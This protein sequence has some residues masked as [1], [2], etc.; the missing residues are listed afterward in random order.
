MVKVK[1]QEETSPFSLLHEF[2]RGPEGNGPL[3]DV[4]ALDRAELA[5]PEH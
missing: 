4:P 5:L 1:I 2:S 3:H